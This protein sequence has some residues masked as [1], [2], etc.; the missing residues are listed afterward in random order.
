MSITVMTLTYSRQNLNRTGTGNGTRI[1]TGTGKM[2][3]MI[4]PIIMNPSHYTRN[5]TRTSSLFTLYENGARTGAGN[6]N[7]TI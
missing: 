7:G 6:G 1:W 5:G 4:D 3:Y 2:A